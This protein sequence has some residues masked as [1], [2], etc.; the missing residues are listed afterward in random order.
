LLPCSC[1]NRA[2]AVQFVSESAKVAGVWRHNAASRAMHIRALKRADHVGIERLLTQ[3][4]L[5]LRDRGG[6]LV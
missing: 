4:A 2:S 1:D 3:R 5:S 6:D